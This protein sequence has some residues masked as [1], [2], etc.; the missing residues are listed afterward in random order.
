MKTVTA[1]LVQGK[2]V[3]LRLDIDVTIENGQILE[4]FRL[5]A[6]LETLKLCLENANS[7]TCMGH[8]GR[9]GGV[10]VPELSVE[11]VV[12]WYEEKLKEMQLPPGK[13]NFLENL[14]FEKGEDEA[15]V[16]YA[17]ELAAM[18]DFLVIESFASHRPAASTTILAALLPHAAGLRF[19]KEVEE[20]K[21]VRENPTRPMVAIIG[22]AKIEDKLGVVN[23]MAKSAD[24]VLIGGKLPK[25]IHEKGL[26]FPPNVLVARM[27]ENGFDLDPE[28]A[29]K[30][31][32]IIKASKMVV[33]AGPMGK[34][35][36]E[37]YREG[38]RVLAQAIVDANVYSVIGGGDTITA[39]S[40]VNL[41]DKMSFISTG[42]GAM[43]KMLADGTLPTIDALNR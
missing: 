40:G 29:Q 1:E 27:A 43:L 28:V 2:K 20:L 8:I 35:E 5:E 19:A 6:G 11:P 3:L 10:E 9:P 32:D 18:G 36:E 30:F 26:T 42:G 21:K 14:R 17:E 13:F 7:V 16:D 25:E 31:A 23:Q 15:S 39:L 34:Y 22:G 41:L 12:S 4:P 37:Q 33:W 24:A 38:T